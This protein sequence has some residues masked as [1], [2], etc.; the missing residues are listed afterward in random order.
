MMSELHWEKG[1]SG[2]A[3]LESWLERGG[4][5]PFDYNRGLSGEAL[6]ADPPPELHLL[7]GTNF[8]R[9]LALI[10]LAEAMLKRAFGAEAVAVR[11]NAAGQG[12]FFQVHLDSTKASVEG[13]KEFIRRAFYH[14]F[15]LSP[16]REFVKTHPGGGA[17][18]VRV[19]RFGQVAELVG[20]MGESDRLS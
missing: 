16:E 2:P 12:D 15:G 7:A 6:S 8:F 18:G 4:A 9:G 5:R 11:V 3:S 14:R 1:V 20:V 10:D 19:D 13:V 17:E